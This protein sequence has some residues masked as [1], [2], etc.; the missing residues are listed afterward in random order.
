M[1]QQIHWFPGH[2][3]KALRDIEERIKMV[4][5]IIEVLDARAPISSINEELEKLSSN[6][7]KLIILS[8]PD[9]A[10]AKITPLLVEKLKKT[11]QE[12]L[13]LNLTDNN[14]GKII[15][16]SVNKLGEEKWKK[17]SLKG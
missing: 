14:A 2:M 6:K 8:K 5:V 1:G 4:D 10:D 9:L 16:K 15:G 7:K 11:Y 13:V 12:V 17:K 3:S